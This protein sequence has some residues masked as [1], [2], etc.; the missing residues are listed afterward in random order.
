[1]TGDHL[2]DDKIIDVEAIKQRTNQRRF[3]GPPDLGEE[4]TIA[5]GHGRQRPT[6]SRSDENDT[7]QRARMARRVMQHISGGMPGGDDARRG[8]GNDRLKE[9]LHERRQGV[10]RPVHG[11][12]RQRAEAG[13]I[14]GDDAK[15]MRQPLHE[16]AHLAAA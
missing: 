2:A 8:L 6:P 5:A 4:R 9:I 1:M 16:R 3:D 7:I 12:T 11:R 13:P 10:G 15:I 14:D